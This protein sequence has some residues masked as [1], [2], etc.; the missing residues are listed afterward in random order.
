MFYLA[1]VTIAYFL[2][3]DNCYSYDKF[4]P[5]YKSVWMMRN[6]IHFNTLANQ[7]NLFPLS[8]WIP[9]CSLV[10]LSEWVLEIAANYYNFPTQNSIGSLSVCI[11]WILLNSL[12]DV[13]S[14]T[15]FCRVL[16][17]ESS[18][19]VGTALLCLPL[20]HLI[21]IIKKGGS[22]KRKLRKVNIYMNFIL[23]ALFCS[24]SYGRD[25]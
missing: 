17:T 5:F 8:S 2:T 24:M 13:T 3:S 10:Y 22:E 19:D 11:C 15:W 9:V 1:F 21:L 4:C 25:H 18:I 16:V 12:Y 7:V 23:D 14:G 20:L 6:I